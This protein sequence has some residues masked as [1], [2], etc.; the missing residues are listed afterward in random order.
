MKIQNIFQGE[1]VEDP[2]KLE[3]VLAL[4]MNDNC[5]IN[6]GYE[7]PKDMQGDKYGY[8]LPVVM[9]SM[10][11][12]RITKHNLVDFIQRLAYMDACGK[13]AIA[14]PNGV[15]DLVELHAKLAGWVSL[16]W[17]LET[18]L[19]HMEAQDF[20]E[21]TEFKITQEVLIEIRDLRSSI[22]KQLESGLPQPAAKELL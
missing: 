6:R 18:D 17:E 21:W 19:S 10:K 1:V 8:Q 9:M 11:M 2:A 15:E 3:R 5:M 16:G 13:A 22:K 7:F 4:T 20:V 12:A 14:L